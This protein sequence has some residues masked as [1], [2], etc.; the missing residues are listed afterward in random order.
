[1]VYL[2]GPAQGYSILLAGNGIAGY[3]EGDGDPYNARY[4]YPQ[5]IAAITND[6][7]VVD[8]LIIADTDNHVIRLLL[9]PLGGTHWRPEM[10]SG[11]LVADYKDGIP[12]LSAY[13]SPAGIT[14]G[15]DGFIYVADSGNDAIRRLDW[16]GNSSTYFYLDEFSPV[17][18]TSSQATHWLYV[19]ATK[20][21]SVN[22]ITGGQAEFLSQGFNN[23][24]HLVWADE[25]GLG[26]LYVADDTSNR[27]RQIDAQSGYF[28]TFAGTSSSGYLNGAA[29]SARFSAPKGIA[30]GPGNELFVVE[31]L[32]HGVRKITEE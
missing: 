24:R 32:N 22:R 1:M 12:E 20:D 14:V 19:T 29:S 15:N 21:Y 18:I 7:G 16:D 8:A 10:L 5:G 4:N 11:Q 9:A 30:I 17:G 3:S 28:L 25:G 6:Q 31:A 13:S 27:I 26:Q 2:E 23:P